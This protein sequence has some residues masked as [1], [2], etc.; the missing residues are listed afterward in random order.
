MTHD[1]A[2]AAGPPAAGERWPI[3]RMCR[4]EEGG[5]TGAQRAGQ[6]TLAASFVFDLVPEG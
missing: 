4:I 6:V 3:G 5:C 1:E 2:P